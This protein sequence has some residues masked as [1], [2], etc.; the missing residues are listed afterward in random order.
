MFL[1]SECRTF[2]VHCSVTSLCVT[3]NDFALVRSHVFWVILKTADE[4]FHLTALET[5]LIHRYEQRKPT[6]THTQRFDD[7]A[8]RVDDVMM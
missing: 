4:I 5:D 2:C 1:H 3:E 8:L 7:R 6:Q